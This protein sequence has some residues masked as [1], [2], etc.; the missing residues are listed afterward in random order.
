MK[1]DERGSVIEGLLRREVPRNKGGDPSFR[2]LEEL[3][4]SFSEEEVVL[5]CNRALYQSEYQRSWHREWERRK[6]AELQPLKD[7]VVEMFKLTKWT[8]ATEEQ[9]RAA[10]AALEKEESNVWL[11]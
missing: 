3:L 9:L 6:K 4:R 11:E 7:K 10:K 8:K 2:S 5:L 1:K